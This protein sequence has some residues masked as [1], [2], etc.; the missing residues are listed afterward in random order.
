VEVLL[1]VVVVLLAVVLVIQGARTRR[2]AEPSSASEVV[3]E[4]DELAATRIRLDERAERLNNREERLTEMAIG[5]QRERERLEAEQGALVGVREDLA[6]LTEQAAAELERIA[7][8]S[9]EQARAELVALAEET[10]REKADELSRQITDDAV[11]EAERTARRVVSSSIERIAVDATAEAVVSSVDIPSEEMKGR[12]I[13]REGRN[14]RA[15]EQTTGVT[16]LVDDTPGVVLLSCF[17]PVRR[18]I[19][20]QALTDLVADGRIDPARIEQAHQKATENVDRGCLEAAEA[21]IDDLGLRGI[22]PGLLPSIGALHLRTSYGQNVLEHSIECARLAG[23]MAAE[24]GLDV[25]ICRRAAFL[26]DLGKAVI[27]HGEG[28]H[29]AEGADLARRFGQDDL[30]VHAIAAHHNEIEPTTAVDVLTQAA[31]AISSS[32]P[33]ARRESVATHV[34]RLEHLE[35]IA[36]RCDGVEKAYA[37]RAGREVR[38]MV[39]PDRVDD[40]DCRELARQI[41]DAVSTELVYPGRVKVTVIRESRATEIAQ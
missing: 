24:L 40:Q 37:L 30:V 41:A 10:A 15:F 39:H 1:G 34:K 5:A 14:I 2:S 29:A 31:D 4:R 17:D 38:V 13:G 33:G 9:A 18:E 12:I 36:M 32:R 16:V 3:A 25:E 21:A 19:A 35:Q 27:T 26:H 28:S 11:A 8:I 6:R 7:G 22:D 23:A 20:R